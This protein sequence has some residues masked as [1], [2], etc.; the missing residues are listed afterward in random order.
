MTSASEIGSPNPVDLH[1]G[2]R[3][4]IRRRMLG[5]SQEQLADAIGLTFQQIQK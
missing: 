3:V 4:R 2:A 5:L 1:V